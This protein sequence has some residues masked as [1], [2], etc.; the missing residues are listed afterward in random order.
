[1]NSPVSDAS[2]S[3]LARERWVSVVCDVLAEHPEWAGVTVGAM[4]QGLLDALDRRSERLSTVSLG[5]Y[6]AL[7][8]RPGVKRRRRD[9]IVDAI[10]ASNFHPTK[11][12]AE[13]LAR[14]ERL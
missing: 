7:S 2:S 10:K 3:E 14:G 8:T 13:M 12:S 4:Q 5:L 1:M 9:V 11:W 6:E